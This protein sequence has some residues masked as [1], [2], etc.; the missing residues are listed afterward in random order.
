LAPFDAALKVLIFFF[1]VIHEWRGSEIKLLKVCSNLNDFPFVQHV[2][3]F[4]LTFRR[5]LTVAGHK[6]SKVHVKM[7]GTV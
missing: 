2:T 6:V 5:E 3:V 7:Q 1:T 4:I